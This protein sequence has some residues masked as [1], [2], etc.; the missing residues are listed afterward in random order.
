[1]IRVTVAYP[2]QKGKKFD[3]DYY[4]NNHLALVHEHL[5]ARGLARVEVDKGI[6]APDPGAP[7]PFVA[8]AY[9][10]FNTVE[11]VHE[12]FKAVGRPVMGDI[13]NFTDIE[14]VIQISETIV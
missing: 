13:P 11:D 8:V 1:M 7:P 12:A 6:S 10:T 5:D 3:W 14:P 2:N 9:L 4:T